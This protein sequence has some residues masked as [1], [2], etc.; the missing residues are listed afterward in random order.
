MNQQ[1]FDTIVKKLIKVESTTGDYHIRNKKSGAYGRYQIMPKTARAYAKKL[2]IPYRE[3]KQPRNQDRIFKAILKDNVRALKRNGIKIS[4]FTIYGAHQQGAGGF[5]A[6]MKNKKL[7]KK[8]ERNLRYNLPKKLRK[9]HRSRLVMVW[10]AY[11]Q[12]KLA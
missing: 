11:W 1:T 5:N 2:N 8:L 10:K 7:T 12:E 6:I 3:W 4:A 9:T